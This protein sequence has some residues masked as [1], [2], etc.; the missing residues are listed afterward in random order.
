MGVSFTA[1]VR[2]PFP[3]EHQVFFGGQVL[4][5]QELV[6]DRFRVWG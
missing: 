5:L 3:A 6:D 1:S 2:T 4:E